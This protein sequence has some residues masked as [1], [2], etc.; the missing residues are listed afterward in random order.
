MNSTRFR[1]TQGG[2]SLIE[3]M[4]GVAIGL[5]V[6][7]GASL[8][9]SS[10]LFENRRLLS[11]TQL[12]QDL[13]AA[14]D[15]IARELRR[16]GAERDFF[17]LQGVWRPGVSTTVFNQFSKYQY[18]PLPVGVT[19]AYWYQ[20]TGGT[21]SRSGFKLV[22]NTIQQ[23]ML[24]DGGAATWQD[25]TDSNAVEVETFSITPSDQ[26]ALQLPCPKLCPDGTQNCWPTVKVRELL[27]SITARSKSYHDVERTMV[28]RVRVRND[29][30][31]FWTPPSP[32]P[33]NYNVNQ[34]CPQ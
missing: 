27:V 17:A 4:V 25:V 33:A 15:I 21:D 18:N 3:L 11:E 28:S 9:V 34:V 5:I 29:F 32:A 12:Q 16:S 6:V 31:Q 19:Y 1:K 2:M 23:R 22:G 24:G 30:V 14:S 26:T 20:P 10:Q 13:R 8:A 7:A